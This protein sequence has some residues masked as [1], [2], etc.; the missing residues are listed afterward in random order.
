MSRHFVD[1]VLPR[2]SGASPAEPSGRVSTAPVKEAPPASAPP[3]PAG[4][5]SPTRGA[6]ERLRRPWSSLLILLLLLAGSVGGGIIG[7]R[8]APVAPSGQTGVLSES[9]TDLQQAVENVSQGARSSV[10]EVTSRNASQ[11]GVASG[12][13]LTA[14]GYIATNDH[15]VRG[16]DTYTVTLADGTSLPARLAGEDAQDDLAVLKV[17]AS[18]LRP[19]TF[20][21]SGAVSVGQFVVAIGSPVGLQNTATL[22]I[23]SALNRT[24]SEPPSGPAAELA[25]LIQTNATLN[26]GN[27]GGAL[28]DLRGRFIGMP[29]LGVAATLSGEDVDGIS[30]SIPSDRVRFVTAQLIHSGRLVHSGQGFVGVRGRMITP[31][32]AAGAGLPAQRGLLV[33]GFTYATNGV[34]PA[35]RAGVQ[36]GD[37]ITMVSG[38]VISG[39]DIFVG[40]ILTRP[41]NTP[42]TVAI[43]RGSQR[44]MISVILGER[45]VSA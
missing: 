8:L 37:V 17:A 27:S 45:P 3:P 34:S 10:V 6:W 40:A 30:F 12:V 2:P 16:F 24:V 20:A 36:I 26:P 38:E 23:V 41:P 28:L 29:T 15:M 1:E 5:L 43:T 35:Q 33:T 19:V 13:I 7:A 21:S 22:G 4:P 25:G 31:E 14:D 32:S 9:V 18:G 44:L 42:V 11:G 39:S